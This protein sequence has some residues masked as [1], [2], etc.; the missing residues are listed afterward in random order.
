MNKNII[1]E[2]KVKVKK[3]RIDDYIFIER[4]N[5]H[6]E[7]KDPL[8]D[9]ITKEGDIGEPGIS[10][11][12]YNQGD[13]WEREWAQLA[14]PS[15]ISTISPMIKS[16]GYDTMDLTNIWYQQYNDNDY[17]GWHIHNTSFSGVYFLE[18][19]ENSSS[20]RFC[21][22]TDFNPF[23]VDAK[24]GDII[25]FPSHL[26]HTSPANRGNRKTSIAFNLRADCRSLNLPF[27]PECNYCKVLNE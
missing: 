8:L 9:L 15:I 25:L 21:V 17:H 20:T 16:M 12:D 18:L 14:I 6:D 23:Q 13:N 22:P 5:N 4:I 26:F 24:E 3:V 11:L 2:K 1:L 7:L 19:D 27:D 10:K